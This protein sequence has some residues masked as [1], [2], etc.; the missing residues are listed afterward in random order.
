M[1]AQDASPGDAPESGF[2]DKMGKIL[3]KVTD[4]NLAVTYWVFYP[5]ILV[6]VTFDVVGRNFFNFPLSWAIEGS[7][8]FLIGCIFLAMGKVEL[9]NSHIMLDIIYDR[10]PRKMKLFADFSTRVLITLWMAATTVRSAIEI[11][12]AYRL[13]ES[14][15]DFR[16]PF[17]PM[18]VVMTFGFF[19][20]T[21]CLLFNALNAFRKMHDKEGGR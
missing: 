1:A 21:F 10:Y 3:D 15:A 9:E 13:M 20:L 11:P 17:W 4:V 7:G 14:G 18:R 6:V 19:V 5:F 12:T 16:Y 2:L 8:L